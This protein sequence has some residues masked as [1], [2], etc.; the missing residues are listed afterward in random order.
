MNVGELKEALTDVDDKYPVVLSIDEWPLS[1]DSICYCRR[2]YGIKSACLQVRDL[3]TS[4]IFTIDGEL[5]ICSG[6]GN[7]KVL[8]PKKDE[9]IAV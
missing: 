5:N 1:H 9:V 8:I 3:H 6:T 2:E 4:C 7:L